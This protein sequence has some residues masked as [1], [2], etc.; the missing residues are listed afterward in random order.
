[1][2]HSEAF[3]VVIVMTSMFLLSTS[4]YMG[5]FSHFLHRDLKRNIAK[6][7]ASERPTHISGLHSG[8]ILRQHT[9]ECGV[10]VLYHI[11]LDII[12][13]RGASQVMKY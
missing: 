11:F 13:G 9:M 8:K 2:L 10:Q 5:T 3:M 1:M 7:E 6:V 4:A 12:I